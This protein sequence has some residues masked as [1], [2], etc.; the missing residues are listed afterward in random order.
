MRFGLATCASL[1]PCPALLI[2]RNGAL[3]R[4]QR[5]LQIT[6]QHGLRRGRISHH[7]AEVPIRFL[8]SRVVTSISPR[9]ADAMALLSVVLAEDDAHFSLSY[10]SVNR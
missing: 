7:T 10:H 3:S 1:L 2:C 6:I 5:N 4:R 9:L 8:D